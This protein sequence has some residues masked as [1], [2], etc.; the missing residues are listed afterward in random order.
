MRQGLGQAKLRAYTFGGPIPTGEVREGCLEEAT[1]KLRGK[2]GRSRPGRRG[3]PKGAVGTGGKRGLCPGASAASAARASRAQGVSL[4]RS[5]D[6]VLP[7]QAQGWA[8][9]KSDAPAAHKERG[10]E[11]SAVRPQER[12]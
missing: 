4:A 8:V 5:L 12:E 6:S 2:E 11:S 3:D 1:S 10:L 9:Q 7:C